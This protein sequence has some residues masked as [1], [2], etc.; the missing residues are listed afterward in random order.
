MARATDKGRFKS[1]VCSA[2]SNIR[3]SA[4]NLAWCKV[5]NRSNDRAAKIS[6]GD[7]PLITLRRCPSPALRSDSFNSNAT[8]VNSGRPVSRSNTGPCTCT[9]V[10]LPIVANLFLAK[11]ASHSTRLAS[12][13][14]ATSSTFAGFA[15]RTATTKSAFR[16]PYFRS[17]HASVIALSMAS[18]RCRSSSSFCARCAS[19]NWRVNSSR[20]LVPRLSASDFESVNPNCFIRLSRNSGFSCRSFNNSSRV[21]FP[22]SLGFAACWLSVTQPF[23]SLGCAT[24]SKPAIV[25]SLTFWTFSPCISVMV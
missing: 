20:L 25:N 10:L 22:F 6:A 11:I 17:L 2:S 23:G 13:K 18:R 7:S 16:S 3:D 21:I 4:S 9:P 5:S 24:I 12:T 14:P 19:A 8:R 15:L 1:L